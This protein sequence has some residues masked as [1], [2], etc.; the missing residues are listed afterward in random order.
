MKK[1]R[2]LIIALLLVA[3]LCLG[4]GYAAMTKVITVNGD[5][6][7]NADN[8]NLK[9]VFTGASF[10]GDSKGT[11]TFS[12][13]AANFDLSTG[14]AAPNDTAV[15]RF[16]IQ[17]KTSDVT[18]TLTGVTISDY[19]VTNENYEVLDETSGDYF[20]ITCKVV[21]GE[22]DATVLWDSTAQSNTSSELSPNET[23][24]VIVTVKLNRTL[25]N[26]VLLNGADV[27][28]NFTAPDAAT[29]ANNG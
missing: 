8:S 19:T 16:P 9:V 4:L 18:A 6:I 28:L 29:A 20:T 5:G 22:N 3:A 13:N 26:K 23:A 10:D 12:D 25:Q 2:T 24:T 27:H 7:L 14:M 21:Q 11:V 1:R 15:M 17:N